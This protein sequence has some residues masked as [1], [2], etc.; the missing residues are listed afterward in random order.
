[1]SE[2]WSFTADEVAPD[3][4]PVFE[5]Q[6]IPL[7]REVPAR[8]AALLDD[9]KVLLRG[10]IHPLAV[11]GDISVEEFAEV[12]SGEGRNEPRTPVGEI[13]HRAE[14][15][16]LFAVTLGAAVTDEITRR[17]REHDLALAAMLDSCASVAAD[18]LAADVERRYA[19]SL[20]GG[21][22]T[23]DA[24]TGVLR[25]SPGY[26]GW[27]VSGQRRLFAHLEPET[28]GITLRG[29]FLMD[30]LKSVSGVIIA[31]PREIH[32]FKDDYDF[33]DACDSRGCRERLR[34]L[35]AGEKVTTRLSRD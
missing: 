25:Y 20:A 27:H 15:L 29:S 21:E 33:C 17:F 11:V 2:V 8:T 16:A 7:D 13:F 18:N 19:A 32:L 14:H 9:A 10:L 23:D 24:T 5:H 28:I 4:D 6:G 3:R 30:P 22:A 31:G 12:Y 35:F 1:M 34:A 26:C